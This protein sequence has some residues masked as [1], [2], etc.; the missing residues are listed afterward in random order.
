MPM[1]P[2]IATS[3]TTMGIIMAII[4]GMAMTAVTSISITTTTTEP[5]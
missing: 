4:M 1:E 5:R 3:T 2:C